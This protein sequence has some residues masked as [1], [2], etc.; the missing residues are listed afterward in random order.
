MNGEDALGADVQQARVLA[1]RARVGGRGRPREPLRG[2]DG[3][4]E[5]DRGWRVR[6]GV[7]E[8]VV[9]AQNLEPIEHRSNV[10][11][12]RRRRLRRRLGRCTRR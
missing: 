4:A 2:R 6:A 1:A 8:R 7:V 10:R 12:R 11:L 5:R 3:G 9:E